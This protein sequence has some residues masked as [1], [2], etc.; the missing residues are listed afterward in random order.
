[1]VREPGF[2]R[3]EPSEGARLRPKIL[4]LPV[5]IL[6]LIAVQLP[7]DTDLLNLQVC[8]KF[9]H[10]ELGGSTAIEKRSS[11]VYDPIRL[12][13]ASSAWKMQWTPSVAESYRRRQ[14]LFHLFSTRNLVPAK[15]NVFGYWKGAVCSALRTEPHSEQRVNLNTFCTLFLN[16][17]LSHTIH[18]ILGE[19]SGAGLN[20]GV[21]KR[22]IDQSNIVFERSGKW[23]VHPKLREVYQ[24]LLFPWYF[25]TVGLM[26][27]NIANH[28]E[29]QQAVYSKVR[30]AEHS[31]DGLKIT[32]YVQIA[33]HAKFWNFHFTHPHGLFRGFPSIV[34]NK[35]HRPLLTKMISLAPYRPRKTWKALSCSAEPDL[36]YTSNPVEDFDDTG[37]G[38]D[39]IEFSD[40]P[41]DYHLLF[42]NDAHSFTRFF[43][44]MSSSFTEY[45][46]KGTESKRPFTGIARVFKVDWYNPAPMAQTVQHVYMI[47]RIS[48]RVPKEALYANHPPEWRPSPAELANR[49]YETIVKACEFIMFPGGTMAMGRWFLEQ[50]DE[51]YLDEKD[52]PD[53]V[54]ERPRGVY[55]MW[56]I[57]MEEGELDN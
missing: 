16:T 45:Y 46:I 34:E 33:N 43:G 38:L 12:R 18:Q 48:R 22:L 1:M 36:W 51:D 20:N 17:V 49:G 3:G 13:P 32:A 5:E 11:N 42:I 2:V 27:T 4:E 25:G 40:L 41:K 39:H 29:C 54:L 10:S 56:A 26:K 31:E 53:E 44:Q 50:P 35:S 24:A 47:K 37:K 6:V 28:E 52:Y 7:S 55:M 8:C 23:V 14:S 19:I 57:P 9:L 21:I 30:L 15:S